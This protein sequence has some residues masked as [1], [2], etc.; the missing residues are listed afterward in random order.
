MADILIVDDHPLVS[1][2]LSQLITYKTG[3]KFRVVGTAR[4]ISDAIKLTCELRPDL[5]VVDVF[6]GDFNGFDLVKEIKRQFPQTG[7]LMLSMH[8]EA[9]YAERALAAGANGYIMKQESSDDI[10]SA[11]SRI[12]QGHMYLN[13]KI[14]TIQQ[15]EKIHRNKRI[16]ARVR[17][18][19]NRERQVFELFGNGW[20]T[21]RIAEE[22]NLSIK[23]IDTYRA[24]IKGKLKLKNANELIHQAVQWVTGSNST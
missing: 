20:T 7:I 3:G 23:T 8:D 18:L 2:A 13:D 19:A 12:L 22:L 16:A 14:V 9:L 4:D 1:E 15:Q 10:I 17:L 6:L 21:R 24:R 11:I 5:V